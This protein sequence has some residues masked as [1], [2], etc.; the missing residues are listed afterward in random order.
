MKVEMETE[1]GQTRPKK[2]NLA[3]I[4]ER[5]LC[6]RTE[7][8]FTSYEGVMSDPNLT[9]T[10]K[11]IHLQKAIDDATRRKV[12]FASLQGKLLQ[13][14]FDRSKEAYKKTLEEVKIKSL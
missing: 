14:C 3:E 9:L 6:K 4:R 5:L 12:Y 11:I 8:R 1:E 10:E 13:S 2:P 7:E